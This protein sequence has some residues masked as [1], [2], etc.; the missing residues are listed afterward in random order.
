MQ[1]TLTWM[2][3]HETESWCV[4]DDEIFPDYEKYNIMAYL[5]KTSYIDGL[6]LEVMEDVCSKLL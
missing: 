1:R 2:N 6:T 4:I 5:V 3:C